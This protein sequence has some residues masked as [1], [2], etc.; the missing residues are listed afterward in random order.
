M[1][2]V[3]DI[4]LIMLLA[5]FQ[6]K[7]LDIPLAVVLVLFLAMLLSFHI[8]LFLAMLLAIDDLVLGT[9]LGQAPGHVLRFVH[10]GHA[11]GFVPGH[12][13]IQSWK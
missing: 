3:S 11:P 8:A 6:A 13:H 7:F 10:P 5:M 1:N 12:A 9:A 4:R 2:L